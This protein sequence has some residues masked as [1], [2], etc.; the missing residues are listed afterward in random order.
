MQMGSCFAY[1]INKLIIH[2]PAWAR[3]TIVKSLQP[4]KSNRRYRLNFS[5]PVVGLYVYSK[6]RSQARS[7]KLGDILQSMT[8]WQVLGK[9]SK[10]LNYSNL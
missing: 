3:G 2:K 9:L 6:W 7:A 8:I 1:G 4:Q 10:S 5:V